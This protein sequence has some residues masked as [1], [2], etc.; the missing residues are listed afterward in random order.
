MVGYSASHATERRNVIPREVIE[1]VCGR[2]VTDGGLKDFL[3]AAKREPLSAL[4]RLTGREDAPVESHL[5]CEVADEVGYEDPGR[6]YWRDGGTRFR[7][8]VG[9]VVSFDARVR[10]AVAEGHVRGCHSK[11]IHERA[12][13]ADGSHV[14]RPNASV[15]E[16]DKGCLV[17]N[18][19]DWVVETLVADPLDSAFDSRNFGVEGR[20]FWP[21]KARRRPREGGHAWSYGSTGSGK[22]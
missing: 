20:S 1:E 5:L 9:A 22:V 13:D 21:G 4:K 18:K 17:V 3:F 15:E 2:L 19:E 10:R 16:R 7:E 14:A 12:V 8:P 11:A 6:D